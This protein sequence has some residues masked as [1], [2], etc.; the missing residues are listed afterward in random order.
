MPIDNG[1]ITAPI[2][3]AT[4]AAFFG[5]AKDV[6]S[7]CT[8]SII[9][10]WAK[11]KP[12]GFNP[13]DPATPSNTHN[14][15]FGYWWAVKLESTI[16]SNIH[17][18]TFDYKKP[19][20]DSFKRLAEFAGYKHDA[21]PNL[22][23]EC[24]YVGQT[25][26]AGL[27]YD[28]FANFSIPTAEQY[29]IDYI[30][31]FKDLLGL[32]SDDPKTV[33]SNIYPVCFFDDYMCVMPYRSIVGGTASVKALSDG[34][35]WNRFF[36]LNLNALHNTIP[37]GITKGSHKI[38]LGVIV[39]HNGTNAPA[40]DGSWQEVQNTWADEIFPMKSLVGQVF[41]VDIPQPAPTATLHLTFG[42]NGISWTYSFDVTDDIPL[43]VQ[44]TISKWENGAAG[45]SVT[46]EVDA[47]PNNSFAPIRTITWRE[48]GITPIIGAN[49]EFRGTI[50][51]SGADGSWTTGT[52][53][54]VSGTYGG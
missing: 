11:Y 10:K 6:A 44:V 30:T 12:T 17:S 22:D 16:P 42:N 27:Q 1:H 14:K 47:N 50:R 33:F 4:V 24:Q 18:H 13:T 25:L 19:T 9:N 38:T 39:R 23:V 7:V 26:N 37:G 32:T 8:T 43:L 53:A 28:T 51:T 15:P 35:V 48:F 29:G 5:T 45:A 21:Q 34:T 36:T 3:L 20:A 31:V 52:G 54:T 49:M 41:K 40:Y 2:G 46:K